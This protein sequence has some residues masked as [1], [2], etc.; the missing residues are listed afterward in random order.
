MGRP[1]N[2]E[3]RRLRRSDL[4]PPSHLNVALK[5]PSPLRHYQYRYDPASQV[6]SGETNG[7][8]VAQATSLVGHDFLHDFTY[9]ATDWTQTALAQ[10]HQL[11]SDT[12][13]MTYP[14]LD[15]VDAVF[16][17]RDLH[18]NTPDDLSNPS[19][20]SNFAMNGLY[21]PCSTV[22]EGAKDSSPQPDKCTTPRHP[23][24]D[25]FTRLSNVQMD[26][27]KRRDRTKKIPEHQEAFR[28]A[29]IDDFIQTASD[30][31]DIG[32]TVATMNHDT[33]IPEISSHDMRGFYFQLMMSGSAAL[34]ILSYLE[35]PETESGASEL[36][37]RGKSMPTICRGLVRMRSSFFALSSIRDSEHLNMIL[38]LT[39]VDHYL[40]QIS[41]V[42]SSIYMATKI[43]GLRQ[44]VEEV[45]GRSQHFRQLVS[46]SL[47]ELRGG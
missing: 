25:L 26:L 27:W 31:C 20:N 13:Y 18:H 19:T 42:L 39:A 3:R 11:T 41:T 38:T 37:W 4:V 8:L 10:E 35:S 30:I 12:S 34:D 23:S 5:A 47:Q 33:A 44:G 6:S 28:S 2:V 22:S 1:K 7:H 9:N 14:A 45:V 15:S 36:Q 29:G 46:R 17:E 32:G 16:H 43:D 21:Q 40:S 24:L